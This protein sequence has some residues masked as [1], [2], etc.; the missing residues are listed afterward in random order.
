MLFSLIMATRGR[1]GEVGGFLDSLLGQEKPAH[2]VGRA[3]QPSPI[4]N[5]Q[6]S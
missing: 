4:D 3:E 1:T 6:V 2:Q 5:G